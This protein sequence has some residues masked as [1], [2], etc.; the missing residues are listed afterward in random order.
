M[1]LQPVP[2]YAYMGHERFALERCEQSSA[3]E[4]AAQLAVPRSPPS[5]R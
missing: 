4:N 3:R 2:T 5:V 1:D